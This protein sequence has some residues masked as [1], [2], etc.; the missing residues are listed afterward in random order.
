MKNNKR[1]FGDQAEAFVAQELRKQG[2]HICELNYQ[3]LYGEIDIIAQKDDLL[4]FVEVKARRNEYDSMYEIV[5]ISK[6]RKLALVAREYISRN[7]INDKICRFDVAFVQTNDTQKTLHY[8]AD[9][10]TVDE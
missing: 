8:I 9:A 7:H 10:F 4:L 2:F 3:K 5:T 1:I 6:Q